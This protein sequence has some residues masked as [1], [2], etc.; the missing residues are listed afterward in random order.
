ML[1]G[2]VLAFLSTWGLTQCSAVSC[3]TL[4][5][6]ARARLALEARDASR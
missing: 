1:V 4:S 3:A 2:A 6:V 5:F